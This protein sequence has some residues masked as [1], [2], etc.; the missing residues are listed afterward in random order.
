MRFT[1]LDE[2]ENADAQNRWVFHFWQHVLMCFDGMC[3]KDPKQILEEQI[4]QAFSTCHKTE[5]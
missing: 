2:D 4:C 1:N 5:R 3:V